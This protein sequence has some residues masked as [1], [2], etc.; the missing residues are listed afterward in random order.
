M[1]FEKTIE[2]ARE[3]GRTFSFLADFSNT[4]EWDPGVAEARRLTEGP[5]VIG[6][7]FEVI[8]LFRGK[9]HRFEYVVTELDEGRRVAV[10]AEGEKAISDDVVT[11]EPAGDGS[12]ITYE[13]V[14]RM[15]GI[16]RLAEPVIAVVFRRMGNDALAGLKRTLDRGS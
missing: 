16:Y 6:S 4:A 13:A 14:S 1:R 12:R 7:R 9:R 11:V 2:V 5:T 15:K 8:A 10:H 3:P